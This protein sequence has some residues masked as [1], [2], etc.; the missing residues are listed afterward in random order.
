[1]TSRVSVTK[2]RHRTQNKP[3]VSSQKF[4]NSEND[5]IS[6][7]NYLEAWG[8]EPR[9]ALRLY[10]LTDRPGPSGLILYPEDRGNNFHRRA[11]DCRSV[12]A[13]TFISRQK[14][15]LPECFLFGAKM[16]KSVPA[17]FALYYG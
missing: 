16:W 14:L 15:L 12:E 7:A 2:T 5:F 8:P 13:L 4:P 3:I 17:E 6:H 9:V 11:T 10:G 1:M